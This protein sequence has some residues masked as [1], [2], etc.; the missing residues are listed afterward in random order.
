MTLG[1]YWNGPYIIRKMVEFNAW[2]RTLTEDE[3]LNYTN[4]ETYYAAKGNLMNSKEK[5]KYNNKFTIDY[6]VTWE[7][8]QCSK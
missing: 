8:V 3:H 5:W 2:N 6:E 1:K 7:S 4:C